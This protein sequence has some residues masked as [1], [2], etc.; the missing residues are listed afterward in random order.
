MPIKG[1]V[2]A[3]DDVEESLRGFYVAEGDGFKLDCPDVKDVSGL[4]R[5]LEDEKTSRR[6]ANER[7]KPF[8]GLDA[9]ACKKALA[10]VE[11]LSKIDP[12]TEAEKLAEERIK[13][14]QETAERE[15]AT[16]HD[17]AA[18]LNDTLRGQLEQ[19]LMKHT[20]DA[21][22]IEHKGNSLLFQNVAAS[23]RV[24]FD[25]D[26]VASISVVDPE[27]GGAVRSDPK[28]GK[29]LTVSQFVAEM[30]ENERFG[31]FFEGTDQSG[32]GARST[33]NNHRGQSLADLAKL[34]PVERMRR[35]RES[36]RG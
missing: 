19:H 21:A 15:H 29:N 16:R 24:T 33:N 7:W 17:K 34:P 22:L 2:G 3:L 4:E 9:D 28:T 31:L 5:A 35:A 18:K 13:I 8:E 11:R 10:D 26:G 36:G 25:D 6:K 30:R 1:F 14:A 23:V 32:S 20:I 12:A 27:N